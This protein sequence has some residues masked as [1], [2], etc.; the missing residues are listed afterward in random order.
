M[1]RWLSVLQLNSNISRKNASS[2]TISKRTYSTKANLHATTGL[3][4]LRRRAVFDISWTPLYLY[5]GVE[6][7]DVGSLRSLRISCGRENRSK[8][9]ATSLQPREQSHFPRFLALLYHLPCFP[10]TRKAYSNTRGKKRKEHSPVSPHQTSDAV[11]IEV[12]S[13][14]VPRQFFC[15]MCVGS[16]IL[17]CSWGFADSRNSSGIS[18]QL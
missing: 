6:G 8:K 4:S 14:C 9:T 16:V 5:Q 1:A 12:V 13:T 3:L 17:T 11:V 10:D 2:H 7:Y 15:V 18:N